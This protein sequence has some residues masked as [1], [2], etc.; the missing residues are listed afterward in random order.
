MEFLQAEWGW[1]V[2]LDL[3]M[4]GLGAAAFVIVVLAKFLGNNRFK[5]TVTLSAWVC[6]ICIAFGV[7]FLLLD[8]GQPLRAMLLP[9]SFTNFSSWMV[10][11]AWFMFG[12]LLFSGVFALLA[13]DKTA[14]IIGHVCRPL[15]ANR[16]IICKVCAIAGGL[17]AFAVTIYT[18][19]LVASAPGVPF[20]NTPLL[21]ATFTLSS[22]FVAL[23]VVLLIASLQERAEGSGTL[24]R[25][26]RISALIVGL[27]CAGVV[28]AYLQY[29]V[30]ASVGAKISALLLTQGTYSWLFWG[31]LVVAGF[32]LPLILLVVQLIVCRKPSTTKVGE[33]NADGELSEEPAIPFAG[34]S[35]YAACVRGA[36]VIF[37]LVTALGAVIGGLSWRFM[38]LAVGLHAPLASPSVTQ[39]FDG[40]TFLLH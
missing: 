18:G 33:I 16:D 3:F 26:L 19:F 14:A 11:G 2:V 22:F 17:L 24:V 37:P 13:T 28:A 12:T 10:Y 34:G 27:V 30:T 25:I 29:S 9:A 7:L 21:P 15:E 23:T 8:V 1:T 36:L 32:A 31:G 4:G 39:M 35:S 5:T 40:V 38:I 20:W 6:V